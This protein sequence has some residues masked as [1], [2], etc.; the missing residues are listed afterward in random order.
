MMSFMKNYAL[1]YFLILFVVWWSDSDSKS[2]VSDSFES[3]NSVSV[4]EEEE[5]PSTELVIGEHQTELGI[6]FIFEGA[7]KDTIYNGTNILPEDATDVHLE[8]R[9]NWGKDSIIGAVEGGFVPYLDINAT[10]MNESTGDQTSVALM[11]HLNLIDNFHYALN[12]KLPGAVNDIYTVIFTIQGDPAIDA[13][14]YHHDFVQ[15]YS[16]MENPSLIP[17]E[18]NLTYK[19]VDFTEIA[20]ATRR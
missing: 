2:N 15:E 11:P 5:G 9:V 19:N 3:V 1:I 16:N 10:V 7:I 18:L 14:L 4:Q 17:E 6:V 8:A 13:L 20:S 12:M